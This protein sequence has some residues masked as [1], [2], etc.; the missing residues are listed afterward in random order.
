MRRYTITTSPAEL[1]A[2][3]DQEG[4]AWTDPHHSLRHSRFVALRHLV[5]TDPFYRFAQY[6]D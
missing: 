3:L 1:H 5:L 2:Y 6:D 4:Q